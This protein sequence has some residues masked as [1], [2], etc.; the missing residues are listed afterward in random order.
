[1]PAST[2]DAAGER[3]ARRRS[4]SVRRKAV[5]MGGTMIGG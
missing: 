1:V 5:V 2:A 3:H 4:G